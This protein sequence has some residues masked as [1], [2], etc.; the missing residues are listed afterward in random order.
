MA[1]DGFSVTV[2]IP[3]YNERSR[4]AEAIRS[5]REQSEPPA[6]I[7]VVD[8]GSQDDTADVARS[9]GVRVLAQANAG[10]AAARNRA[11]REARSPWVAFCDADDVWLPRKLELNRS[12]H[13]VRPD[14]AFLF[15]DYE[16]VRGGTIVVPS[17]FADAPS[18]SASRSPAA[19]GFS[20][21]EGRVLARALAEYNFVHPSTVVV[22]RRLVV[23]RNVFFDETLRRD[24]TCLIPEDLEWYLRVLRVTGAVAVDEVVE[25]CRLHEGSMSANRTRLYY[26]LVKL[27]DAVVANPSAYAEDAGVAFAQQRRA[28]LRKAAMVALGELRFDAAYERLADA[29]QQRFVSRDQALVLFAAIARFAPARPVAVALIVVWQRFLGP[30]LRTLRHRRAAT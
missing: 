12:A 4:I 21:F 26:G 6:E 10:V 29:Q 25:Q 27:A 22:D 28:I 8:D 24:A 14:A 30:L 1:S 11:L 13:E 7:L 15:G 18:F 20:Y 19:P 3:A 9:C 2:V 16:S 23:E 5:I 17:V